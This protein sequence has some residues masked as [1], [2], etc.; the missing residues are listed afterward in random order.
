[1]ELTIT[2]LN[3]DLNSENKARIRQKASRMFNKICDNVQRINV[4]LN[5]ING[6]KGGK[7]K[8]CRVVIH[9]AGIPDIVISDNQ[10]SISSAVNIALSRAR[11][12]LIKKLKRKNKNMPANTVLNTPYQE[13]ETSL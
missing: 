9:A 2:D 1:M 3:V 10:K 12:T 5:D 4:T 6:P 11:V 7:D 13:S 8:L